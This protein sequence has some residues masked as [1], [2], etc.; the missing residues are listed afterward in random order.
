MLSLGIPATPFTCLFLPVPEPGVDTYTDAS[1]SWG[2]AMLLLSGNKYVSATYEIPS[3]FSRTW[4]HFKERK[5]VY[6]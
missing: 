2:R 6:Q 5:L 4:F 1:D 3:W